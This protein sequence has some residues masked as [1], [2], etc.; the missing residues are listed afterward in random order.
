MLGIFHERFI[1]VKEQ[2]KNI[3]QIVLCQMSGEEP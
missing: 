1:K 3:C 2:K